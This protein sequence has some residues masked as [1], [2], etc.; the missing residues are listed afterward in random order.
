MS[1]TADT[2]EKCCHLPRHD[3]NSIAERRSDLDFRIEAWQPVAVIIVHRSFLSAKGARPQS[4]SGGGKGVAGERMLGCRPTA[5]QTNARVTSRQLCGR[6][7]R[8]DRVTALMI[9]QPLGPMPRLCSCYAPFRSWLRG[10]SIW[11][12]PSQRRSEHR[13]RVRQ[14]ASLPP[15]TQPHA[16]RRRAVRHQER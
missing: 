1:S 14:D 8:N 16:P 5:D 4:L 11:I 9:L 6:A 2:A 7:P 15:V 3:R 13:S 10:F 12:Y